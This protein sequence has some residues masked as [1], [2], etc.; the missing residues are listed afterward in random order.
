MGAAMMVYA[1]FYSK[2]KNF[3]LMPRATM[4]ELRHNFFDSLPALFLPAIILG[5]ILGGIF[6]PT[7][8]AAVGAFYAILLGMFLYRNLS[9]KGLLEILGNA[10]LLGATTFC[11]L[12]G[13]AVFGLVLTHNHIPQL[14]CDFF[15]G[16]SDNVNVVL[17]LV[18]IALLILG[19]LMDCTPILLIL[20][21]SLV[22]LGRRL[23]VDD[24]QF[25]VM[26]VLNVVIGLITPPVG[27][28][29]FVTQR[30]AGIS[31]ARMFKS[32][33]PYIVVLLV[34][35]LLVTFWPPLTTWLPNLL[36]G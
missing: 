5:G 15:V 10:A 17:L 36:I 6:T 13:S 16:L 14:L 12:Y 20:G 19:M 21:G 1:Y 22:M 4:K 26:C 24:I 31:T 35:L 29:L 28:I 23:G 30:I 33:L 7:E 9:V 11:M 25:G 18:N 32:I 27:I 2:K 8:A 34:V 3:P